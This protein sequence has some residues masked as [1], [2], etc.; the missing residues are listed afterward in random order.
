MFTFPL[1][2]FVRFLFCAVFVFP[3]VLLPTAEPY[4]FS[5]FVPQLVRPCLSLFRFIFFLVVFFRPFS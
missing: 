2:D 1:R 5:V 3:L 4:S